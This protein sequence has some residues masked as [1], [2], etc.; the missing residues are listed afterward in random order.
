MIVVNATCLVPVLTSYPLQTFR[1]TLSNTI[2]ELSMLVSVSG[3]EPWA[4]NAHREPRE[5]EHFFN[6]TLDFDDNFQ[7]LK[8]L[9][10]TSTLKY[11]PCSLSIL[12]VRDAFS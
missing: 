11:P 7:L 5:K 10:I 8:Y 4:A 9:A 3:P 12:S 1:S 2:G 6:M